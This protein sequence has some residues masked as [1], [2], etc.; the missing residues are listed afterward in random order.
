MGYTDGKVYP[1]V[2]GGQ[3]SEGGGDGWIWKTTIVDPSGTGLDEGRT[4]NID[5]KCFMKMGE[6]AGRRFLRPKVIRCS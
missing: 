6:G 2:L 5:E 1:V 3:R 4:T